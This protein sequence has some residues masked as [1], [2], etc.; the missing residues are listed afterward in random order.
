MLMG[1]EKEKL[2]LPKQRNLK[3]LFGASSSQSLFLGVFISDDMMKRAFPHLYSSHALP[4]ILDPPGIFLLCS[5][6]RKW[7][8]GAPP[9]HST[10]H[11]SPFIFSP[12][13]QSKELKADINRRGSHIEPSERDLIDLR[14][15]YEIPL[16]GIMRHPKATERAKAPPPG[17]RS[18]FSVTLENG[19][20]L[21]VH[22][23]VG[24]VLSM[25]DCLLACVTPPAEFFL[26]SFSQ[27]TQKDKFLY[28]VADKRP[29]P[30]HFYTDSRVLKAAGLFPIS[31]VDLGA[32]EAPRFTFNVPDH[33]P[34]PPPAIR[35]A[36][37]NHLPLSNGKQFLR[38]GRSGKSP[39]KKVPPFP[40]VYSFV[41]PFVASILT[42]ATCFRSRHPLENQLHWVLVM[43]PWSPRVL[44]LISSFSVLGDKKEKAQEEGAL[45]RSLRNLT[46]E[47]NTFQEKY[48]DR[49]R[50][51]HRGC[52]VELEGMQAKRDSALLERDASMKERDALKKEGKSLRAG[53][54]EMLQANDRLLG[55]LTKSQRQAQIMKA[56]LE[57]IRTSEGLSDLV[58][59]SDAG[60]DL[61]L[62]HF[63]LALGRTI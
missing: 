37:P 12:P 36:S 60:R 58:Q 21:P 41:D 42:W 16:S 23:Y 10:G 24:D 38:G 1:R 63:S 32:L 7:V 31:D 46:A 25:A 20:R 57:G 18:I 54:D 53:K 62:R 30:L 9:S 22:P 55:Q 5:Y 43:S 15:C 33:A 6:S 50:L 39:T 8:L 49:R 27:R 56:S 14:S 13:P 2:D 44:E 52:K 40:W 29:M 51:S 11:Q 45:Q 35:A 34:L 26:T 47:H 48:A 28:F 59:G 17:L 19:L 4:V 3:M 61:L